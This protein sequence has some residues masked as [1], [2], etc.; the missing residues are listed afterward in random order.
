[1]CCVGNLLDMA[2]T[3][4]HLVEGSLLVFRCTLWSE[5]ITWSNSSDMYFTYRKHGQRKQ[6]VP[7]K[8][9]SVVNDSTLMMQYPNISRNFDSAQFACF[10]KNDTFVDQME[11]TVDSKFS[12]ETF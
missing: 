3:D 10:A 1:M 12:K 7:A 4:P 8:Y 11:I 9:Y 2:P 5:V 6:R